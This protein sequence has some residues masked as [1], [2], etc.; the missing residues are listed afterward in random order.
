MVTKVVINYMKRIFF[1]CIA[2]FLGLIAIII[3]LPDKNTAKQTETQ[4]NEAKVYQYKLADHNGYIA[5]FNL[6]KAEPV[7]VYNILTDSLPANDIQSLENGIYAE[8]AEELTL[9][10]E[11]YTS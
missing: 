8:S 5:L 4:N 2:L 1:I 9:L 6:N 3:Q 7:E 10:I 11:E